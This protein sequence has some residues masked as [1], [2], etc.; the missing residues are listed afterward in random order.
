[1]ARTAGQRNLDASREMGDLTSQFM[2]A[3]RPSLPYDSII[4][5]STHPSFCKKKLYPRQK[6]LLR[7]I[8]LETEQMTAYDIDVISEWINNFGKKKEPYGVNQ[9]IW[10]RVAYLKRRGYRRFP[11]VQAVQGR[12]GSKGMIG[13][14]LGAESLAW[15]LS[16]DDPQAFYGVEPGKDLYL[17][18]IATNMIQAKQFQFA[19]IRTTVESCR[20]FEKYISTT[21]EDKLHLRTNADKRRIA[22]MRARKIPIEHEIASL[23]CV[24]MSST[25]SSGRGGT[26]FANFFDELA[27]MITGSGGPRSSE[28]VY[29]AYQPSLDQFGK[30]SFSYVAS[31]PYTKV[32]KFYDLYVAGRVTMEEYD[33]KY[34]IVS[35]RENADLMDEL[36]PEEAF[37]E[38]TADPEMLVI[39]LPSWELYRDWEKSPSLGGPRFRRAIQVYDDRM[40]RLERRN[41]TKFKVERKAQFAEVEDAYLDPDKVDQ[42][43]LPFWGERILE[44]QTYG[45]LSRVYEGHADPGRTNANFAVTIA[46]LEQSPTPDD[47]GQ[48]WPHVIVDYMKVWSPKNYPDHTIDYVQVG[49]ELEKLIEKFPSLNRFSLDQWNSASFIANLKKRFKGSPRIIEA[50]F[51]DKENQKR[52]EYFKSAINLGWVHCFKDNFYENGESL[53]EL[54]LKF[55]Q[56]KNGKVVKQDF[57]PVTTK[58]LSDT[59]MEVTYRLLHDSLDK[60]QRA[61]LGEQ[62]IATALPSGRVEDPNSNWSRSTRTNAA[63]ARKVL[64]EMRTRGVMNRRGVGYQGQGRGRR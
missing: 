13:G 37:L 8:Y 1:M 51:S 43:F 20:Y 60:W 49:E 40:K 10:E 15:M 63:S 34:G 24:A 28:E 42:M 46:H 56:E 38:L 48:F 59:V 26:G 19:D 14:I 41:P 7:L 54:E 44:P 4:D 53:L 29:E 27:H 31:S 2:G 47:H 32:G 6:T 33:R 11:H 36:D 52:A 21:K 16:L 17:H 12:R 35:N 30:D 9:D 62:S 3:L 18:T 45:M 64:D 55:L 50:E 57:G 61:L 25:S 22:E 39:Q 58:D 23:R 5:F